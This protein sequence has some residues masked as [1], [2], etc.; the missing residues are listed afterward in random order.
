MNRKYVLTVV[1]DTML[2]IGAAMIGGLV[3]SITEKKSK[4]SSNEVITS[5]NETLRDELFK[6][7]RVNDE[8][9]KKLEE[10]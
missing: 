10:A 8:L 7:Y 3:V 6:S 5:V 1:S 4:S 9:K 2:C